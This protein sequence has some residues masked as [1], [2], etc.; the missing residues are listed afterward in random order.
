MGG[1]IM[2]SERKGPTEAHLPRSKQYV[3]PDA[4]ALEEL[5]QYRIGLDGDPFHNAEN[6]KEEPRGA[7]KAHAD[8][9]VADAVGWIAALHFARVAGGTVREA[10]NVMNVTP[11][12]APQGA[13][14]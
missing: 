12:N 9:V 3:N 13:Y 2:G 8:R 6:Q 14:A 5:R 1:K 10:L 4:A 7:K 11:E